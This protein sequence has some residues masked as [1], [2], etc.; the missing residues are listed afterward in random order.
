MVSAVRFCP[1]APF[2]LYGFQPRHDALSARPSESPVPRFWLMKCEPSAY[3]IDDLARDGRTCWEGV[4]N[5]QAR[6]F[7]RD[8]MRVG[9]GVLFYASNADPAG[10]TGV[11]RICREGH[12]DHF[13]WEPGH[14]Y[15]DARSTAE[16]PVWY[17]VDIEY[18]ERFPG[19]VGLAALKATPGLEK[20]MV[21]Q[22]GSR[23]SVQP[24]TAEE[25]DVVVRLGRAM[26]PPDG[27]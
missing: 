15:F 22:K 9:D 23:L 13:A 6:N 21:V 10:V 25:F 17:M 4:R 18:V 24:V 27:Q 14:H 20:M 16:K 19:T 5:Y 3:T 12:P 11:A 2:F 8:D 7:M 1:S 26:Q